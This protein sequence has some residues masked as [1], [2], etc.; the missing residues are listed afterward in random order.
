MSYPKENSQLACP[1]VRKVKFRFAI[2]ALEP[3]RTFWQN[4]PFSEVHFFQLFLYLCEDSRD[5]IV[6]AP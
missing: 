4:C 6:A 1:G 2:F 5:H 3:L